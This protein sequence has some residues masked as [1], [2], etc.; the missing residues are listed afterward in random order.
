MLLSQRC[1]Q[2]IEYGLTCNLLDIE[3]LSSD[4]YDQFGIAQGSKVD[5]ED[6]ISESV[7]QLGGHLQAQPRFARAAGSGQGEQAHVLTAQQRCDGSHFLFSPD[8]WCW[9]DGQVVGVALEGLERGELG[10]Q[11]RHDKLVQMTG[12]F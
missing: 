7:A 2:Q 4:G 5:E 9:L 8:E 3:C 10:R 6:A 11:T 1:F 12:T